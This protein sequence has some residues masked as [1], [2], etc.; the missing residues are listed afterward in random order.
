MNHF[1]ADKMA[2]LEEIK[3]LYASQYVIIITICYN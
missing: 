3:E 1:K 2:P